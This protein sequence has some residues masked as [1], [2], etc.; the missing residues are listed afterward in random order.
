MEMNECGENND[1]NT[2]LFQ[3]IGPLRVRDLKQM[4]NK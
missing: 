4:C 2:L 3:R 1:K